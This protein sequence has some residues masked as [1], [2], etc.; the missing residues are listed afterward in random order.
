MEFPLYDERILRYEQPRFRITTPTEETAATAGGFIG[1]LG[2][3]T[4]AIYLSHKQ[5]V[6]MIDFSPISFP[7]KMP[8]QSSAELSS[9]HSILS[10]GNQS[11]QAITQPHV[12]VPTPRAAEQ[13]EVP[14]ESQIGGVVGVTMLAAF[15]AAAIVSGVRYIKHWRKVSFKSELSAEG[16]RKWHDSATASAAKDV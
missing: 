12:S 11:A 15:T 9:L 3:I 13:L 6:G 2:S 8:L 4:A 1:F 10:N 7:M 16:L 5:H 14:L